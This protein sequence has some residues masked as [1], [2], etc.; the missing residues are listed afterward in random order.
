MADLSYFGKKTVED[1]NLCNKRVLLRCDFNVPFDDVG[2]ISNTKRID[3]SLD[4]IR[5]L[6]KNNAKIIIVSH[7]GRPKGVSRQEFSLEPVADYLSK[8]L[9]AKVKFIKRDVRDDAQESLTTLE[10]GEVA[11][12]ENIRFYKEEEQDDL[13][14]SKKLASLADVYVNDAF[15]TTH[16][17]HASTHGV[18]RFLPAAC[19]FLIK[20]ELD[21]LSEILNKPKRPFVAVLGGSK[22][23]DKIGV[24]ENLLSKVDIMIAAGGMAYTFLNALGYSIGSSVFE[25]DKVSLAKDIM[26]KAKELNVRFILPVDTVVGETFAPKTKS[27]VVSADSIP[28]GWAGLDIG[29]KT[30]KLF[31]E[32]ICSASTILWNGP[33]GVFEWKN[34]RE[35]TLSVAKAIAQSDA[36]SVVGGGDSTAAVEMLGFADKLTHIS[37]GGGAMLELLAGKELPGIAALD[38][39]K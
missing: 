24:I 38:D 20:K 22:V 33:V 3:V 19:G 15:G 2:K 16:R 23:S 5:Y 32:V 37:T 36:V 26:A 13:E 10:A 39:K 12:L 34:F 21:I 11:L 8:V 17:A 30:M 31:S 25:V 28:E 6:I 1:I 4:T 14:F 29:P 18:A 9:G 7:L 27:M 35:G